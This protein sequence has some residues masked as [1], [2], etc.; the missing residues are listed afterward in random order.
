VPDP[1][2]KIIAVITGERGQREIV[3]PLAAVGV[4]CLVLD[5]ELLRARNRLPYLRFIRGV[6]HLFRARPGAI[7]F[8]DMGSAFLAVI[9]LVARLRGMKVFLRL[10]GDPFAETHDQLRFH[11]QQREWPQFLRAGVSWLLDRPL[12]AAVDHFV[13]VSE[14][15]VR[16]LAIAP[17]AS[18]VRIPVPVEAFPPREHQPVS[19]LRL[20]AVTNFNYPQKIAALGRFLDQHGEFLKAQGF[21]CT[22]AG[23]GIAWESFRSRHAGYAAFP[24]FVRDVARLYAEYDIFVHF[25]DLDAFPYVVLEAQAAGLPVIVNRDCGMLEQVE[26]GV[27][28]YIVDLADEA[29]VRARLLALRDSVPARA[30]IGASARGIIEARYSLPAIGAAL[31]EALDRR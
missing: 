16:R 22:V 18:V 17:R 14:W 27:N 12:F 11:W 29:A 15:I 8:T 13:P 6:S 19:P 23:A 2:P 28:G 3:R 30:A 24:G 31:R 1:L 5:W 25:S 10:R 7:V 9:L 20:L 4:R 26:D 21:A